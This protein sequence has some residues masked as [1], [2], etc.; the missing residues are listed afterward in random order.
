MFRERHLPAVMFLMKKHT[1]HA[2]MV[3]EEVAADANTAVKLH[4][5]AQAEEEAKEGSQ[6]ERKV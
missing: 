4:A 2:R 3:A 1:E 6:H 5:A